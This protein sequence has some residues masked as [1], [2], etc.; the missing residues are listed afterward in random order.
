MAL[1]H[2]LFLVN[3]SAIGT[4]CFLLFLWISLVFSFSQIASYAI[5]SIFTIDH[6][7]EIQDIGVPVSILSLTVASSIWASVWLGIEQSPSFGH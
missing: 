5:S 2:D 6:W 3:E 7:A 4:K 1:L